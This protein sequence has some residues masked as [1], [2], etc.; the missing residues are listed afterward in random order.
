LNSLKKIGTV[1][2]IYDG[3]LTS[4]IQVDT[5]RHGDQLFPVRIVKRG[6]TVLP[7]PRA[8][9]KLT[10]VEFS[11]RGNNYDLV[12]YMALN[13]V[14]GLLILKDGKIAFEDYELGNTESTRWMSMSI[15]KSITASLVGAAIQDG[16]IQSVADQVTNYLPM[17]MGSAYDGVSI[18]SLLQM[19]SG[20]RWDETY[21]NPRSDRRRMLDA[22]ISQRPGAI[23]EMISRLPR[24]ASPGSVWNYSTGET[25]I[26][27]ALVQAA[28]G[29]PLADYLSDR[30]WAKFGMESDATWWLES[31]NGLEV[32]GSGLSATLRDFGR[33]G[34]F[35]L[36]D[37]IA[38]D[39]R[40]LPIGWVHEAG[41]PK[42][43]GGKLVNYGYM[44]W[45]LAAG[46]G[47]PNETAY[48]AIGIFGQ[49]IYMNPKERIVIVVWSALPKPK[50]S[51]PIVD[52]DFFAAAVAGLR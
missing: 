22:Q 3:V 36:G 5:F 41:T 7:L 47:S 20:V 45:P 35:L 28:V 29:R 48:Q 16:Y 33:F 10:G 2:E 1:R 52:E 49:H 15:A 32:G 8:A 25:H 4:D 13:R 40:I 18:A 9:A 31:P 21:T 46:E 39:E 43:I 34:L 26:A 14:T 51:A 37:G 42:I 11:S 27:G 30:I 50:D 38:A 44:F 17:L 23:L 6:A 19:A 24:A 12:D